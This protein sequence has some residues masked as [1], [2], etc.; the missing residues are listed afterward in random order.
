MKLN[1]NYVQTLVFIVICLFAI[2]FWSQP[3]QRKLPYG[4]FDAISHFELGDY[5]AYNDKSIVYLPD[6][7][8]IRYGLD[9]KFK[10]HTLWYAPTFHSALAVGE[11]LGG[12]RVVP[13]FLLNTIMATFII[14]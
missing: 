8:D 10:P 9:N 14:I 2:Y 3:L 12:E 1:K 6:Y 13:I 4:E 7:I 5:M 11:I